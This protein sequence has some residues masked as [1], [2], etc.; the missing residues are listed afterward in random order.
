M[1]SAAS[2]L[3]VEVLSLVVGSSDFLVNVLEKIVRLSSEEDSDEFVISNLFLDGVAIS[4]DGWW[5]GLLGDPADD[6]VLG[7][8]TSV[9]NFFTVPKLKRIL[10]FYN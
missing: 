9:L 10:F 3:S 6:G 5:S 1:G 4:K 7:S 2:I 8:A